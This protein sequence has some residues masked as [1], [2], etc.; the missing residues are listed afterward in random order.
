MLRIGMI[1]YVFRVIG[2]LGELAIARRRAMEKTIQQ[3]MASKYREYQ[4]SKAHKTH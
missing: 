3:I 2:I 1:L 4:N